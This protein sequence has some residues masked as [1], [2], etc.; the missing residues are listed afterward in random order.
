MTGPLNRLRIRGK[1]LAALGLLLFAITGLGGFAILRIHA[2]DTVITDLSD[3]WLPSA[4]VAGDLSIEFEKLRARE[5]Q[6]IL[7]TDDRR[8]HSIG[9]TVE[10]HKLFEDALARY[11]PLVSAGEEQGLAQRI[12]AAWASYKPL[13]EQMLAAARAGDNARASEILFRGTTQ[14]L[15]SLRES[16]GASR[17]FQLDNGRIAA[18]K[19]KALGSSAYAW[20]IAT[21]GLTLA[22]SIAVGFA[23]VRA[24][25]GPIMGMTAAMRRL[26]ERDMAVSIP[27]TGR[28]DEI[29]QMASAV[30]VFRDSMIE[31]DRLSAEAEASRASREAR[32]AQ[33]EGLVRGFQERAGEMVRTLS[34]ASTELEATARGMS[35]TAEGTST[36]AGRVV[37]AAEQAS[38]GVQ[39]VAAAAEELTASIGEISRQVSQATT[40]AGRAVQD[41]RQTDATVQALAEG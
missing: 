41:A 20:I 37:S 17:R 31:A 24:I 25:S 27:G 40:V 19:G 13:S 28:G 22:F 33:M 14:A 12:D 8:A 18:D 35:S 36:Q 39:T 15:S 3:N 32:A 2:L 34:S 9:L 11:R 1:I 30:A 38:T 21:L 10:S 6:M 5:T 23:L 7:R 4:H 16:I 26:A 29:G